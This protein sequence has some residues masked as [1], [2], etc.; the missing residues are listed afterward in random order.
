MDL[1][2]YIIGFVKK[3]LGYDDF[4]VLMELLLA[5]PLG[6]IFY[7]IKSAREKKLFSLTIGMLMLTIAFGIHVFHSLI[8]ILV[9][10][11]FLC[12]FPR[13]CHILVFL[14][15][16]VYLICIVQSSAPFKPKN[17]PLPVQGVHMVLTLKLISLGFR[18]HDRYI[19]LKK[20][21][22]EMIRYKTS[23]ICDL[24]FLDILSYCYCFCGIFTGP[25]FEY[26]TFCSALRDRKDTKITEKSYKLV[27]KKLSLFMICS[28]SHILLKINFPTRELQSTNYLKHTPFIRKIVFMILSLISL[29]Y[30]YYAAWLLAEASCASSTIGIKNQNNKSDDIKIKV[31]PNIETNGEAKNFQNIQELVVNVDIFSVEKSLAPST[32]ARYW[33]MSVQRW[34]VFYIYKRVPLKSR[35]FKQLI[36]FGFSA[37]WHGLH[38]GYYLFFLV[39]PFMF[40][41]EQEL[42]VLVPLTPYFKQFRYLYMLASFCLTHISFVY[43]AIGF[44]MLDWQRTF[45]IW[46][47]QYFFGHILLLILVMLLFLIKKKWPNFFSVKHNK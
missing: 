44:V 19:H 1:G 31:G 15:N 17:L 43:F 2:E 12:I 38:P 22:S 33:N 24:N 18:V 25:V 6:F 37:V 39:L 8:C 27:Q 30:R 11:L 13:F 20:T 29:R 28:I 23:S 36:T 5:I 7:H 10:Y 46:K 16:M 21:K 14:F 32:I 4:M 40:K 45:D 35:L 3:Q 9:T 26:D 34:L 42:K 47:A 41:V